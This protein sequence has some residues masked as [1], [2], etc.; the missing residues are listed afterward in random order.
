MAI[1]TA[2]IE[3]EVQ[4]L[5]EKNRQIKETAKQIM[6]TSQNVSAELRSGDIE[7]ISTVLDEYEF[8]LE[9]ACSVLTSHAV[10]KLPSQNSPNRYKVGTAIAVPTI[11]LIQKFLFMKKFSKTKQNQVNQSVSVIGKTVVK[12]SILPFLRW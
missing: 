3:R 7:K 9:Q 1:E 12:W 10:I 8:Q 11:F 4:R 5:Q 6:T 2:S